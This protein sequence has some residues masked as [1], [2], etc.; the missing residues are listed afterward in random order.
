MSEH[1]SRS[2]NSFFIT[3][4][5][6]Y[7]YLGGYLTIDDF[8]I[9]IPSIGL[10]RKFTTIALLS[11]FEINEVYINDSYLLILHFEGGKRNISSNLMSK[12]DEYLEVKKLI[13]IKSN[14]NNI[15]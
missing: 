5:K 11:I 3:E 15:S 10:K 1:V 13:L 7:K 4:E 2:R 6:K 8:K 12:K 14:N 9:R